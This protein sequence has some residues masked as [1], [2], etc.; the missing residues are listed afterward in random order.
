MIHTTCQIL[1]VPPLSGAQLSSSWPL[2]SS[3]PLSPRLL[4]PNG[5]VP[6]SLPYVEVLTLGTPEHDLI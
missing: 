5:A 3:V 6:P 4:G 1:R 2:A